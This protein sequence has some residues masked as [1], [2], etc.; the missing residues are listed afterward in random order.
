M[1]QTVWKGIEQ[2]SIVMVKTP[3]EESLNCV[4]TKKGSFRYAIS[5][6]CLNLWF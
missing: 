1:L 4:E 6:T 3:T 5:V 2:D